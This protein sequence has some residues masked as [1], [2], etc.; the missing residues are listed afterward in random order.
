[1]LVDLLKNCPQDGFSIQHLPKI[2]GDKQTAEDKQSKLVS[3][4][5][6]IQHLLNSNAYDVLLASCNLAHILTHKGNDFVSSSSEGFM[7]KSILFSAV[8]R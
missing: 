7:D 6:F 2:F 8:I 1:M 3:E 5:H 4:K